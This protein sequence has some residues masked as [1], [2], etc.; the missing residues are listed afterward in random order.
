M[1]HRRCAIS[2]TPI[3]IYE[4]A[5]ATFSANSSILSAEFRSPNIIVKKLTPSRLR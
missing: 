1:A 4:N 2:Q 5:G 3:L